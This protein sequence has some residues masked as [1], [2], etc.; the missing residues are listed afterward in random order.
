MW[1]ILCFCASL[2]LLRPI[3]KHPHINY[4]CQGRRCICQQLQTS[5]RANTIR[6]PPGR[7]PRPAASTSAPPTLH[8]AVQLFHEMR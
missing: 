8:A 4:K 7:N 3:L 6:Q 2:L 5:L 1:G